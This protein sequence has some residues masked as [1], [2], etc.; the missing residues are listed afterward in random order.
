MNQKQDLDV[1]LLLSRLCTSAKSSQILMVV[2]QLY[3]FLII[4]G[5]LLLVVI[6]L[7]KL[8]HPSESQF[9]HL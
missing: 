9:P 2:P 8:L 7:A 6:N 1:F 3:R 5:L 4:L